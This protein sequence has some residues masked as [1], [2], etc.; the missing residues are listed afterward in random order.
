MCV[1]VGVLTSKGLLDVD[2][3]SSAGFHESAVLALGPLPADLAADNSLVLQIAFVTGDNFDRGEFP[4]F[5]SPAANFR[6]LFSQQP[7]IL[8]KSVFG[9]D[10]NHVQEPGEALERSTVGDVVDQKEGV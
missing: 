3:F 9:F 2:H 10:I 8:F 7:R 1:S 5:F 4:A 6:A